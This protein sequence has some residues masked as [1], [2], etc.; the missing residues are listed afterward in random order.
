MQY[1]ILR[2]YPKFMDEGIYKYRYSKEDF[3]RYK[4]NINSI[5]NYEKWKNGINYKTIRKI[6]IGGKLHKKL[7]YDDFYIKKYNLYSYSYVPFTELDGIDIDLYIKETDKLK[8]ETLLYN[9]TVMDI[10][11]KIVNLEKWDHCIEFEGVKYG[12][13]KIHNNIHRENDCNGNVIESTICI[14]ECRDCRGTNSFIEPCSCKYE[15]Y[16]ECLK[17]KYIARN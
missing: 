3:E 13:H 1:S 17:C 2:E 10:I 8:N 9:S 12:I 16:L 6:K 15:T 11:N 14:R 5:Q 4:K 7:G